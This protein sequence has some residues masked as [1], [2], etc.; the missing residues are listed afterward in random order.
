[1]AEAEFIKQVQQF[2]SNL[3]GPEH[4]TVDADQDLIGEVG[5]DSLQL[6]ALLRFVEQ[7]RGQEL[8]DVPEFGEFN[9]RN[10]YQQLMV[11]AN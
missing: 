2:L 11:V 1:M 8:L 4:D 10:A 7:L 5:L 6:I 9:I 3:R